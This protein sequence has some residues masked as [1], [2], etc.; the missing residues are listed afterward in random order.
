MFDGISFLEEYGIPFSSHGKN[1]SSSGDWVGLDCPFC[2]DDST[3]LGYNITNGVFV[4]WKCGFHPQIE[5][6]K[7]FA[8][9]DWRKAKRIVEKFGGLERQRFTR[10]NKE[11][12]I[13]VTF[14]VGTLPELGKRH[15]S[16]LKKR[17]FDPDKIKATWDIR[18]TGPIGP[19]KN[20]IIAPI[21]QNNKLVSYVGRDITEKQSERYKAC[22][23]ENERIPHKNCLYGLDLAISKTVIVVEGISD[24]WRMGIG[25]ICTFG[26]KVTKVQIL[27]IKQRFDKVFFLFDP[28][29]EAQK[30]AE[31]AVLDLCLLGSNAENIFIG[32]N[33]DPGE[34][35]DKEASYII[36]DLLIR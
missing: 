24:V 28:E 35:S 3:H 26:T 31:K 21:Y 29:E 7:T 23:Q 30:L 6:V 12:D 11:K 13:N 27:L 1:I 10:I 32:G 2:S 36:R 5:V 19:Y 17:N 20:R 34:L 8:N 15:I 33:K 16:Y 22:N 18:G 4:C 14:P 25:S 9:V